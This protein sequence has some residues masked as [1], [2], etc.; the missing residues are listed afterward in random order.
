[1][2]ARQALKEPLLH[3][4]LLGAALFLLF[5][6]LNRGALEA[7]DEVIVDRATI[8]S[9]TT[10]FERVWRRPPTAAEMRGLVDSWI[11]EE[12][13][14]REGVALG[15]DIN[16]SVVRR[17]IAQKMMFIGDG[18]V[19][20]EPSEAELEAWLRANADDY[21]IEPVFSFEQVYFDPGR[22]GDNLDDRLQ[23][24]LTELGQ[25]PGK[26]EGDATLLPER[27]RSARA[28]EVA[29]TFGADF[30]ETL[31][32]LPVGEWQG[33]VRSGYGLHLVRLEEVVPDRQPALE[34]VRAAIERDWSAAQVE[35]LGEAFYQ[36]MRERYT[37]RISADLPAGSGTAASSNR[38]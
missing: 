1:M 6:W 5:A 38:R 18:V 20:S 25:S 16:D 13:L 27:L 32:S 4:L 19:P 22:H 37:V 28:G 10:Q 36:S 15:L 29:R 9:L 17:R 7:P 26:P 30:A 35:I 24:L 14:Y 11:R 21:R 31:A 8:E 34:E 23:E 12:I 3:F 33:P 2:R